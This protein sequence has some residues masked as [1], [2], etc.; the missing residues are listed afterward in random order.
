MAIQY[1]T[2]SAWGAQPPKGPNALWRTGNPKGLVIHWVGG[3]TMNLDNKPHSACLSAVRSIQANEMAK[4]YNDIAYNLLACPHGVLIEGRGTAVAGAANGG[5]SGA[6]ANYASLCLLLGKG[7]IFN[8]KYQPVIAEARRIFGGNL[9]AHRQVN[10]T[11]CPGIEIT[12]WV[13]NANSQITPPTPI[14]ENELS[15]SQWNPLERIDLVNQVA[16][17]VSKRLTGGVNIVTGKVFNPTLNDY[18]VLI[19]TAVT[20]ALTAAIAN[21]PGSTAVDTDKVA[22]AV[23]ADLAAR[24]AE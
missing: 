24:L 1:D 10:F 18:T 17:E 11:Q 19:V 9:L 2:R 22:K 14:E 20:N 3:G 21:I 6:N 16:E 5:T 23:A 12:E 4:E 15:W 8:V 7:D 13:I